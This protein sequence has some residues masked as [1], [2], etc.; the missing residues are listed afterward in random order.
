MTII[1]KMWRPALLLGLAAIAAGCQE[2]NGP[3]SLGKLNAAAALA[4]YNAM[5]GV[6]QSSGWKNFR[7]TAAG[8]DAMGAAA[9]G[10]A[11]VALEDLLPGRDPSAFAAALGAFS[12]NSPSIP[13]ISDGNRG[14]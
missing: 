10:R 13:L 2:T 3:G 9:A 5:D 4:D 1:K 11:A 7:M 6:L 8:M 12:T 14:K